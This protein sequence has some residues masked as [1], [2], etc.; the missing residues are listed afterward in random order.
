ML[1]GRMAMHLGKGLAPQCSQATTLI[2]GTAQLK[3]IC[4]E[5]E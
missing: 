1:E 4:H 2:E 5:Q 3:N